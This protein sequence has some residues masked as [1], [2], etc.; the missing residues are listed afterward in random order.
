[1]QQCHFTYTTQFSATQAEVCHE[2]YRK[3]CRYTPVTKVCDGQGPEQCRTVYE[4]S[5][6]TKYLEKQPGQFVSDARCHKLPVKVCGAGCVYEDGVEKCHDKAVTSV[7]EVPEEVCD[8]NPEKLCRLTTKL[9]PRL[10]PQEECTMVPQ[11]SCHLSYSTQTLAKK[12]RTTKWCLEEDADNKRDEKEEN[13]VAIENNALETDLIEESIYY[14]NAADIPELSI[15]VDIKSS[16]DSDSIPSA[17]DPNIEED[18]LTA[19]SIGSKVENQIS[20]IQV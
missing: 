15:D 13:K 20:G 5:C 12:I 7:V 8:L 3:Y 19:P 17:Y 6:S 11:E 18:T 4:S 9:V 10:T 1:M 16:D 2:N 14:P